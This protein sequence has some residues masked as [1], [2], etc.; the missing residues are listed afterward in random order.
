MRKYRGVVAF[1]LLTCSSVV[2]A[3]DWQVIGGG[4]ATCKEWQSG[5]PELKRE[6]LGWM[7]G[8]ASATNLQFASEGKKEMRME[9]MTYEYLQREIDTKCSDNGA[10]STSM[11]EIMLDILMRFPKQD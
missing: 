11:I 7:T 9:L 10:S 8:V 5:G 4:N 1:A 6:V 2:A 3:S